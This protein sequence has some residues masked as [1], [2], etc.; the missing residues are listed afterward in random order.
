MKQIK[1]NIFQECTDQTQIKENG[2]V[3]GNEKYLWKYS[4]SKC[5]YIFIFKK[6]EY[7]TICRKTEKIKDDIS[8][9]NETTENNILLLI[10]ILFI[11]F[12]MIIN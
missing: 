2:E 3:T 4:K 11:L 6:I 12:Q 7:N 10:N 9:E 5:Y 1:D 8:S